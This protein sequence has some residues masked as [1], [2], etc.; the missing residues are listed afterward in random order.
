M[1]DRPSLRSIFRGPRGRL[2]A[3]FLMTEFAASVSGLSYAAVLPVAA[4]ELDGLAL[5]GAAV[6]ATGVVS[7]AVIP[8]GAV[9]YSR[10]GPR[11]QLWASTV[12]YLIGVGLSALAPSMGV[13]VAGLAVRGIAA[14][15]LGGLGLGVLSGLYDEPKERERAFGLFAAMWVLPS[16]VGPA[17]NVLLLTTV[18][19][20][21]SMVWPAAVLVASRILVSRSL[22]IVEWT[23]TESRVRVRGASAFV[24]IAVGFVL[25]QAG[26]GADFAWSTSI[27]VAALVVVVAVPFRIALRRTVPNELRAQSG[28]WMLALVCGSYFAINAFVPLVAAA[29]IDPSGA[30]GAV[31]VALGPLIWAALSASGLGAR[32][33]SRA[34]AAFAALTFPIAAA[35]L[36]GWV[37][38]MPESTGLGI[39]VLVIVVVLI[40]LAMGIVY[41]RIMTA[42]FEGFRGSNGTTRVH[43]G[44]V[45]GASEDIGTVAGVTLLAGIGGATIVAGVVPPGLTAASFAVALAVL[46]AL[47]RRSRLWK[48]PDTP[49]AGASTGR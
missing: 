20:R 45:L 6:A 35:T 40:G 21:W 12:V 1:A 8:F 14:G 41:P 42:T 30:L 44:V 43:G 18:G 22:A 26:V 3:A 33:S 4:L 48:E 29:Y 36:A 7:I 13:L 10:W 23:P 47:A 37:A 34:A 25:A 31:L 39:G 28:G 17:V 27:A 16:L 38:W 2:L 24:A 32:V 49:N 15:M 19:W 46:W 9:L 5:Y 11:R